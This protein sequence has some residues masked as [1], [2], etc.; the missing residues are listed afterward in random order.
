MEAG[1]ILKGNPKS[2][3]YSCRRS[4]PDAKITGSIKTNTSLYI[5]GYKNTPGFFSP[6]NHLRGIGIQDRP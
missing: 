4:E 3:K 6:E 1:M 2:L 5:V